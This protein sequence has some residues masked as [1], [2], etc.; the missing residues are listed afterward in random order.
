MRNDAPASSFDPRLSGG[1]VSMRP[2]V[3]SGA[4]MAAALLRALI[5]ALRF[6]LAS[7]S[8]PPGQEV[9]LCFVPCANTGSVQAF[10]PTGVGDL[11]PGSCSAHC[12]R[13]GCQFAALSSETCCCGNQL[14]TLLVS[15]CF[16][17]SL[18]EGTIDVIE[19]SEKQSPIYYVPLGNVGSGHEGSESQ[20]EGP[21]FLYMSLSACP[22]GEQAGRTLGVKVSGKLAGCW[23]QTAGSSRKPVEV[24][25]VTQQADM[26][27]GREVLLCWGLTHKQREKIL[28]D[29]EKANS[30][31][32]DCLKNTLVVVCLFISDRSQDVSDNKM[33]AGD[34]SDDNELL[35]L[36]VEA[37]SNH[38]SDNPRDGICTEK[39]CYRELLFDLAKGVASNLTCLVSCSIS[40]K[41]DATV[42]LLVNAKVKHRGSSCTAGAEAAA[43]LLFTRSGP[44]A[45]QL[46]AENRVYFQ[47]KSVIMCVKGKRKSE[48][49]DI[50]TEQ[51]PA[52]SEK[53]DV[54]IYAERQVYPT[55]KDIIFLV[56]TDIPDPV[57]FLW[58]FGDSRGARTGLRTITKRYHNPGR[59]NVVAAASWGQM[60]VTSGVFP[61][62]IQRVVKLSRLV[63]QA[64]VLRNRTLTVTCRVNAGT[65]LTFVWSFGDGTTRPGLSTTR[66]VFHRLGEF[67]VKV[68]A[69]NLISSAS[70]SSYVFVVDRPCRPPPVKNMGPLKR[71]F[72]RH[73]VIHLGVTFESDV[74]C[75]ISEGLRYSWTLLGSGGQI[76]NLPHTDTQRQSLIL[77]SH[78]LQYDT[79]MAI[80]RV[81][82]I[83]SVV[84]SNYTV[85]FQVKPSPPVAFI[86]GGTNVFIGKTSSNVVTL[87]GQ[88]S[89][90]PDF[91]KNPLSYT[92]ACKPVSTITSSCFDQDILTSSP[93]LKF[94]PSL[95]KPK[96][97]QFQFTLT[98][99]SGERSA[100]SEAFLTVTSHLTGKVSVFCHQC[101]G[102]HVNWDRSFSIRALC[103]DCSIHSELIQYTWSLYL[104]NASSK[105]IT[106][107]PFCYTVDV[108]SPSAILEDPSTSTLTPEMSK[109]SRDQPD[110]SVA[111][112][113]PLLDLSRSGS[114]HTSVL[115]QDTGRPWSREIQSESSADLRYAFPLMEADDV[116]HQLVSSETG[117]GDYDAPYPSV[118]E[119]D[120]GV[121]AGRSYG[122]DTER[123][124][125]IDNS[126]SDLMPLQNEGSNLVDPKPSVAIQEPTLLDFHRDAVE[127]GLFESYT[128]TGIS[129]TLLIFRPFSLKP[130]SIY[131][132]QVTA[133]SQNN[134]IGQ[135]QLFLKTSPVPE[136]VRCQVRPVEGME[137]HTPFSIFC[138]SGREDLEYK[139]SYS[140]GD[141]PARTM[142][143]GRDFLYYFSLPSGDPRDDHE[144]K[145]YIEIRSSSSGSATKPC[146]VAVRVRPSFIGNDSSSSPFHRDPALKLSESL[147]ILSTLVS[148]GNPV[149]I[150]NYVSLL[151]SVLNKL[152]QDAEA[153]THSQRHTRN[154]LIRTLCDFKGSDEKSVADSIIILNELLQ[155]TNQVTLTSVRHVA[156]FVGSVSERL[157]EFSANRESLINSVSY[158]LQ[159]VTSC[160]CT[161]K[162]ADRFNRTRVL[163]PGSPTAQNAKD[164][165]NAS[166]SCAQESPAGPHLQHGGAAAA[167]R[168]GQL[169]EEILQTA[170]DL[171]LRDVLPHEAKQHRVTTG[172]VDLLASSQN[173]T[174]VI[175]RSGFTTVR[176][177]AALIQSAFGLQAGRAR[178]SEQQSCVFR[179]LT[180]LDRNLCSR[181][182]QLETGGDFTLTS[183]PQ[184]TG[185]VVDF[186]LF[187]CNR[188]KIQIHSLPQ[189]VD[190]EIQLPQRNESSTGRYVLLRNQ[191]SYHNFSISQQLLQQAIQITVAFTPLPSKPF[192][193][194]LLFRMF[195][196]PTP[197]MHHLKRIHQWEQ[198][199]IR[200]TL[201][202]SCLSAAGVAHMALLD[203]EFARLHR[204]RLQSEQ[205]SYSVTADSSLCLS[206]DGQQG[207]W[208]HR[209]CR[210]RQSDASSAVNCSCYQLRPLTVYQ[211][212]IQIS[213]VTGD[214]DPFL[215]ASSDPVVLSILAVLLVLYILGLVWSQRADV[216][217]KENQRLYFLPDNNP[218]DPYHYAVCIH[219]G[220]CSA[221]RMTAKVYM[222]LHG[223]D[224]VSQ[225][226]ELQVPGCTLFRRNTKDTFILSAADSLGPVRGVHVWHDNSG[227][228]PDWYLKQVAVTEVSRGPAAE[229]S[230]LFDGELWLSVNEG[231]G[232]V[233]R[234]LRVSSGEMHPVKML[235]LRFFDYLADFH[236]W[237]C[238]YSCPSPS[239]HTHTQRLSVC[240]LLLSGYACANTVIISH[241]DDQLPFEVGVV[242]VSAVSVT[243][244]LQSVMVV[245]PV[246]AL[247]SFLFRLTGNTQSGSGI[248]RAKREKTPQDDFQETFSADDSELD[249]HLSWDGSWRWKQEALKKKYQDSDVNSISSIR[250]SKSTDEES[251]IQTRSDDRLQ[252]LL[253]TSKGRAER[254]E[255]ERCRRRNAEQQKKPRTPSFWCRSL[256]WTLCALL[257]LSCL[258][259]TVENGM[260]FSSSQVVLWIHSLCVSLLGCMFFIQPAL[261]FGVTLTVCF[262]Y[263]EAENC[264]CFFSKKDPDEPEQF[265]KAD[266]CEKTSSSVEKLLRARHLRLA[267]P[268]ALAELKKTCGKRRRE[269]VIQ[270]TLRNFSSC[271]IMLLLMVC[272]IISG[273]SVKEHQN[274]NKAVKRHFIRHNFTSSS[275]KTH[276]GWWEWSQSSLLHYLYQNS[277]A[278][279]EQ[280]HVV[281]GEPVIQK[282]EGSSIFQNPVLTNPLTEKAAAV[283]L[284]RTK[285][286][287]AS[288]LKTLKSSSWMNRGTVAL[289]VQF[290]L[291]SPAP[292]LFS[293]VSLSSE[294]SPDGVLLHSVKVQ[295]VRVL[296]TPEPWDYVAMVSKLLFLFLILLQ[297]Y[298]QV[299][300]VAQQ[301]LMGCR[302]RPWM[303]LDVSLLPVTLICYSCLIYR[304]TMIMEVVSLLQT[305]RRGRVDV[306]AAASWEQNIRTLWGVVFFLLTIKCVTLLGMN[307]TLSSSAAVLSQTL[308]SLFWP[309]VSSLILLL[310]LSCS[311]HLLHAGSCWPFSP[312]PR[313]LLALLRRYRGL[314]VKNNP[315]RSGQDFSHWAVLFLTNA[316][317][318][319]AMV[320]G[321][322]SLLVKMARRPQSRNIT[323]TT[324]ELLSYLRMK[325]SEFTG[326]QKRARMDDHDKRRTRV[327][328]ELESSIDELLFR[329]D[330]LSNSMDQTHRYR[331]G[332]SPVLPAPPQSS[333]M[334]T[335]EYLKSQ[336]VV[337][338][339][340]TQEPHEET[341][342]PAA[343]LFRSK[344]ETET[345]KISEGTSE[346]LKIQNWMASPES[347]SSETLWS[348]DIC[349]KQP[350]LQ[351]G[352]NHSC[353]FSGTHYKLVEVLVHKELESGEPGEP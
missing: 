154:V 10:T 27:E 2:S 58:D 224:G 182:A 269:A 174:S 42:S 208:T 76:I 288:K 281:I 304:S 178:L 39:H 216:L 344:V 272:I 331:E 14:H 175:V 12:L 108:S 18:R 87:D 56:V 202:P 75:D 268:P 254:P 102:D 107:V 294:Q 68:I 240:L 349:E 153:N 267:R 251:A 311:G 322:I 124:S 213:Q 278:K 353:W 270:E 65:N 138:T 123:F 151:T 26:S 227:D 112:F 74:E 305:Q 15:V 44:V 312:V 214:L 239:S 226:K 246:A 30:S 137:L 299:L 52:Q 130:R 315:L 332:D 223:E 60:S 190:T 73:E 348:E 99:L 47:S 211:Q 266:L 336:I 92:W 155:V 162:A 184:L 41:S 289:K 169:V 247:I 110:Q 179:V 109:E 93:V 148:L 25:T 143:Q 118:E 119:G 338:T 55:N 233:E 46:R 207:A 352:T 43:V 90:D 9:P 180:Q 340:K 263:K 142:Y 206:W 83:G 234:K 69:S 116:A 245:L 218:A 244:G 125:P 271:T 282:T 62:E 21:L 183:F 238:V 291:Y 204:S 63:H 134:W 64:S 115:D 7:S 17:S 342:P 117:S 273:S 114:S 33:A 212:Q 335:Q 265:I 160:S 111:L 320:I 94:P 326:R 194:M 61:V 327:L 57:E 286:E 133:K 97:D 106:E 257:S 67:T 221:A 159:V 292:H 101:Q 19:G 314:E 307:R 252:K 217:S 146:P 8:S 248:Q 343:R 135:T 191:I 189:P 131:M 145:I 210:T 325:V 228:S 308:S 341:T 127:K 230:W 283:S 319:T 274:L 262:W 66:H 285:S 79:F 150:R 36:T 199:T 3:R 88:K 215:S 120:S 181:D 81:Q 259:V 317:V 258:V 261:I 136:G 70:L 45:N 48:A 128:Y 122:T 196:R 96:F 121:S 23:K 29:V 28:E 351:A 313:S 140:I 139:Y 203:A 40:G 164:S 298:N 222:V 132:L 337:K 296:H 350:E 339:Q 50:T 177:P 38:S 141:R 103:E 345:P 279:P 323:F 163:E 4:D 297:S 188:R 173:R 80:A 53:K 1:S 264:H 321:V 78:L 82:V 34:I 144:V 171:M 236:M 328:E 333:N 253:L 249:R 242:D 176:M 59:Y 49:K 32:A 20:S 16:I 193:V 84:Y 301:G 100:S 105:P 310:A 156:T 255:Q 86:Q 302:R 168:R 98:V 205:I 198:N 147:R 330:V 293:S 225:T 334:D 149:E 161:S 11:D 172:P 200:V 71:Q 201:P 318:R 24:E 346:T 250:E 324:G 77:Q 290:T 187:K 316:A 287:A 303:W 113:A 186:S 85:A 280:P 5:L 51:P 235:F 219:T 195:E 284:G 300:I 13:D 275:I 277:S 185:P 306:S 260:R 197:S 170:A 157:P 232:R 152:G 329:L 209:G 166:D 192:P 309:V 295:S 37:E 256:A 72:Q 167:N 220:L 22:E 237:L 229:R 35:K 104:V 126:E 91:P 165:E 89:Y 347:T 129:S 231:D 54:R 31:S 241:A 6:A 243:T 158:C 95:L 276:E